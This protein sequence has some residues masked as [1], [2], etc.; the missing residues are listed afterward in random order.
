MMADSL[1]MLVERW[2]EIAEGSEAERPVEAGTLYECAEELAGAVRRI[3]GLIERWRACGGGC[4]TPRDCA[5]ELEQEVSRCVGFK[6]DAVVSPMATVRE[7]LEHY[8]LRDASS[9]A[10]A[11]GLPKDQAQALLTGEPT[12]TPYLASALEKA[13][14]V[15]ARFWLTLQTNFD[16]HRARIAQQPERSG[17]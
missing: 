12:L 7:T 8:Q 14:R 3:E 17:T 2:R 4:S 9:L 6:P 1:Q 5:H 10:T 15:S 16:Q 11:A 13:T